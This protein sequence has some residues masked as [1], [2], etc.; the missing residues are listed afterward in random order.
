MNLTPSI[1][2]R[3]IE[4]VTSGNTY[5]AIFYEGKLD[6]P[7]CFLDEEDIGKLKGDLE[8]EAKYVKTIQD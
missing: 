3:K 7:I 4:T 5:W 8:F 6:K 1:R 2:I